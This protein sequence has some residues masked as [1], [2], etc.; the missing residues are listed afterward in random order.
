MTSVFVMI[1]ALVV[2]IVAI[3]LASII[4]VVDSLNE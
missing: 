3:G 2:V 4:Y 1:S